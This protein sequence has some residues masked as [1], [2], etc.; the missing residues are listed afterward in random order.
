M[1]GREHF[2]SKLRDQQKVRKDL[3][4][5]ILRVFHEAGANAPEASL[6]IADVAS[7]IG[8][9]VNVVLMEFQAG[10]MGDASMPVLPTAVHWPLSVDSRFFVARTR[11]E[12]DFYWDTL[13]RAAWAIDAQLGYVAE[14]AERNRMPREEYDA[15]GTDE[16]LPH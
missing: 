2:M 1:D 11:A 8:Q 10:P 14:L 13:T 5:S 12:L 7:A 3:I 6:S 4:V 9:P 15:P 16:G